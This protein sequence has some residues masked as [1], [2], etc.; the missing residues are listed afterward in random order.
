MRTAMAR[1]LALVAALLVGGACGGAKKGV[2]AD[3]SAGTID[4]GASELGVDDLRVPKV[5]PALCD[6]ADKEVESFDLNGDG[7]PNLWKLYKT[8]IEK[9]TQLRVLTCKQVDLDRDGRKDYVVHYDD[10]G[11]ILVEEFDFDFDGRFDARYH[12][13]R[14]TGKRYLVERT[15]G[16]DARPTV[17]EK[18][19]DHGRIESVRRDRNGDGKPDYWELY[20]DGVLEAIL[21]DDDHDGRVDRQERLVAAPAAAP[22]PPADPAPAPGAET[23]EDG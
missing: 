15:A 13:D 22:A 20:R 11:A 18:F 16:F 23:G 21:Y 8:T 12:Y 1:G 4:L 10:T 14:R 19:D 9:G 3:G 2:K 6:T 7:R 17:W 5:D